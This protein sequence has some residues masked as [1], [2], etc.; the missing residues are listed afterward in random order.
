MIN[1]APHHPKDESGETLQEYPAPIVA[2]VTTASVPPAASSVISFGAN[3]TVV[4]VTALNASLAIKWGSASVVAVAG[5]TANFDHIVSVNST[6]RF[7]IP[8]QLQGVTGSIVGANTLNGL[9][10]TMAVIATGSVLSA[11]T[12]Y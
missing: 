8:R 9:Y 11:Y 1:Y 5:S 2:K 4:E 6:R 3:T 10:S 12:E 7:V